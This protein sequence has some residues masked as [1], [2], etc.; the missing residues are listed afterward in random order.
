MSS[1]KA[2]A[3]AWLCLYAGEKEAYE[4]TLCMIQS[5]IL[6]DTDNICVGTG[7]HQ[8][9]EITKLLPWCI[10][11]LIPYNSIKY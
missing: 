2:V 10:R 3:I 5:Y 11:A 4:V 8:F 9:K 7:V 1:F 6:L